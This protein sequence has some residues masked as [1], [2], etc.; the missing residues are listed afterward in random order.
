LKEYTFAWL[1]LQ[2]CRYQA[3]KNQLQSLYM[4]F[5]GARKDD[6]II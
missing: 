1:E 4:L 6:Q 3:I 2:A 5:E